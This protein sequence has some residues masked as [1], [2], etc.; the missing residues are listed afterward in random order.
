MGVNAVFGM[1]PSV[2]L[3]WTGRKIRYQTKNVVP[4]GVVPAGG[5]GNTSTGAIAVDA[6]EGLTAAMTGKGRPIGLN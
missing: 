6:S 2:A 1:L 5:R 4:T 3:E